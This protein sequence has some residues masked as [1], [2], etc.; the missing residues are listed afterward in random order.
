MKAVILMDK[1]HQNESELSETIQEMKT[2]LICSIYQEHIPMF[3]AELPYKDRRALESSLG[4]LISS[5]HE[6]FSVLHGCLG[7][8]PF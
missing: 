1:E 5:L 7:V 2:L 4:K 3:L 8:Y 6:G